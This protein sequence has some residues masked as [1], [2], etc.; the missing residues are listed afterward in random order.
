MLSFSNIKGRIYIILIYWD[1][2]GMQELADNLLFDYI[3][4]YNANFS[5]I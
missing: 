1:I 4:F 3:L 5:N 2:I